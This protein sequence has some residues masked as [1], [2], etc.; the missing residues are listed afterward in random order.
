MG[1]GQQGRA[2]DAP[3]LILSH[4]IHVSPACLNN[5]GGGAREHETLKTNI[6]SHCH[7][8]QRKSLCALFTESV[9]KC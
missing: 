9:Y 2:A 3:L 1:K 8:Q 6:Q 5:R 7:D 4:K